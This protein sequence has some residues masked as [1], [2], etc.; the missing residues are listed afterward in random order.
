MGYVLAIHGGCEEIRPERFSPESEQAHLAVLQ[1]SLDA[2]DSILKPG[3]TALDA[4]QAAIVI[5]EDS[6]LF[7]AGRGSV[8]SHEGRNEMDAAL[9]RGQ[10][11]TAGAVAGVG[12]IKNP[13]AAARLV[14]E[15]SRHVL[16]TGRGAEEFAALQGLEQADP[17]YFYE[18]RR[19]DELLAARQQDEHQEQDPVGGSKKL[20]TVGAVCLDQHGEL[21]AGSST[22]GTT[23]KKYGRVGDSPIIGAGVY[24][25]NAVC[26]VSCTGEGEYF[27]RRVAAHRVAALMQFQGLNL[28]Q[29]A[30]LVLEDIQNMGGLGGLIAVDIS[31]H[32]V[33]PFMTQGMY[34]GLLR[35]GHRPWV[36]MYGPAEAGDGSSHASAGPAAK[37]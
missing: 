30:A 37:A 4:V 1:Q 26:A 10:D 28:A 31:G 9:M 7:N 16:L 13:V 29:A 12:S 19:W 8:F 25:D 14:L 5:L 24:A 21:A 11:L 35:Q 3:G 33:L 34:R 32:A 23:N 6:S 2:G 17:E 27:L 15:N 22:G 36:A 20:G 18:Q